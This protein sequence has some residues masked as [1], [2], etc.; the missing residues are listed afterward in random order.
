MV[1]GLRTAHN[2]VYGVKTVL[3]K[4]SDTVELLGRNLISMDEYSDG[5]FG[6]GGAQRKAQ[7]ELRERPLW[8][9]L[10]TSL[11]FEGIVLA[12]AGWIF[13]RRDF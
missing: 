6:G 8:W 11:A 4:T 5:F 12:L 2:I 3:P 10:G 13:C 7:R 1:T 9:V